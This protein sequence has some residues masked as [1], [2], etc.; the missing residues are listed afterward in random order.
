MSQPSDRMRTYACPDDCGHHCRITMA[1][2]EP[3]TAHECPRQ[4]GFMYGWKE[5][6]TLPPRRR[7][8]VRH[9]CGKCRHVMA[10]I[11]CERG[12]SRGYQDCYEPEEAD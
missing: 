12:H 3:I 4:R 2:K 10:G 5:M 1:S 6:E 8:T 9:L 11:P 7:I